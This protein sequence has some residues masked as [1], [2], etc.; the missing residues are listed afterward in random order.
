[1]TYDFG[2]T[3]LKAAVVGAG[4]HIVAES[5]VTYP[6]SQ[7]HAGWA[8]QDP[9]RLWE[10]A[11][12]AGRT[13]MA[14]AGLDAVA[15]RSVVMVAPWKAIIPVSADG[16]VL[17]EAIIWMDGRANDQ[18][19][20]LNERLGEFVG[21][22]QEYWPR[23]MWLRENLPEVWDR[24]A[25]LMGMSTYL[26]WRATGTVTT[27]PSD[28]FVHGTAASDE[29]LARILAAAGL[30]DSLAK[31][32]PPHPATDVVGRLT[33]RAAAELGLAPGTPVLG[34]FGDLPAITVGSGPVGVGATH[35]Y[36]GTSSWLVALTEPGK[37][38]GAPLTFTLD[39]HFD[40][41]VYPLQTGC[42]AYDWVVEQL[43]RAEK[44]ALGDAIHDLVAAEVEQVAP[45]ADDLL[46]THWLNGELPPLAKAAR[47][48]FLNLST[49][50]DRRH[51]V[52]AMMESICYSHRRSLD[53][54][55]AA[56]GAHL[57]EVRVVGGGALSSVWMQ[58]LADIL[59]R[60]VVVPRNPR[61][62]GVL[63]AYYCS[64][65]G[66]GAAPALTAVPRGAT[67]DT[68]FEPRPEHRAVHDR[69]YGAYLQIH[70]ALSGLF[71]EL[72]AR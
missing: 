44:A 6:V 39:D 26:K 15:V 12:E 17:T 3:S 19:R 54:L 52:R 49:V 71:E 58:M 29:R 51:M 1:M 36:F 50:H 33:D 2:T 8:E 64:V 66:L 57:L 13:A 28:D 42:L 68:T 4:G 46:A 69:L 67:D 62:V 61:H 10:A 38:L 63:G 45:G 35:L 7:P 53:A 55:E 30:D 56:D 18:A 70:P 22:G 25:W 43:Y 31:F 23:L 20:R 41:A 32:P 37:T 65:V 14:R 27:D 47:G 40:A 21:T 9:A 72:N 59:G 60:R 16:A 48:V 11:G 24:S 34:G 5:T